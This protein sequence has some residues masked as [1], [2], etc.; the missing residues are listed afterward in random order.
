MCESLVVV[1]FRCRKKSFHL[2]RFI[3]FR[4]LI[5]TNRSNQRPSI[6]VLPF[7][8]SIFLQF[9]LCSLGRPSAC[10]PTKQNVGAIIV[11]FT[12]AA[13]IKNR[14]RVRK[15]SSKNDSSLQELLD[16]FG[17]GQTAKIYPFQFPSTGIKEYMCSSSCSAFAKPILLP[18]IFSF[19]RE[20]CSVCALIYLSMKI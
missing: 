14:I 10:L 17:G 6:F 2:Q 18:V 11:A 4:S 8:L 3:V 20:C 9:V 5:C 1:A 12:T 13:A 16:D 19:S 15:Y 7:F